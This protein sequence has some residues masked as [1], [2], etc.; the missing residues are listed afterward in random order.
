MRI[1]SCRRHPIFTASAILVLVAVLWRSFVWEPPGYCPFRPTAVAFDSRGHATFVGGKTRR[2][3]GEYFRRRSRTQVGGMTVL[4]PPGWRPTETRWEDNAMITGVAFHPDS[5]SVVASVSHLIHSGNVLP[6]GV[7]R[8]RTPSAP[9]ERLFGAPHGPSWPLYGVRFARG[10]AAI[11]AYGTG[12]RESVMCW[13]TATGKPQ[14]SHK[15]QC[16]GLAVSPDGETVAVGVR[17]SEAIQL[18][19][20]GTGEIRREVREP[21]CV[22][23]GDYADGGRLLILGGKAAGGPILCGWDLEANRAAWTTTVPDPPAGV[24][25]QPG[26]KLLVV[27]QVG[28]V[29]LIDATTGGTTRTLET[30]GPVTCLAFSMDGRFLAVGGGEKE[31]DTGFAQVLPLG[32]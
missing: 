31:A 19:N 9:D 23:P 25:V 21:G 30:Y 13:D 2:S 32:E 6:N 20:V 10:S 11:V 7:V 17:G 4:S 29:L 26:G 24:A 8:V 18:R 15:L 3:D 14:W 5:S 22:W 27:G 1:R 12:F 16:T 28:K